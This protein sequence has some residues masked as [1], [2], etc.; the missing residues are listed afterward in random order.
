MS[1]AIRSSPKCSAGSLVG[2]SASVEITIGFNAEHIDRILSESEA[3][4]MREHREAM[5]AAIKSE[6]IGWKYKGRNLATVGRSRAGW[7][8]EEQTTE[9]TRTIIIKNDARGYYSGK[10]YAGYVARR[11]GGIPEWKIVWENLLESNVPAFV[12]DLEAAISSAIDAPGPAK[13]VRKN[14]ASKYKTLKIEG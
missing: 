14:K 8:A 12:A 11:K 7:H 5:I 6:W 2:E 3:R 1:Y 13:K 10:P 4:L 9:G